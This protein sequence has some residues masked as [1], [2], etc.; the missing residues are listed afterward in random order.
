MIS[1]R[2][3]SFAA[4][5][6]TFIVLGGTLVGLSCAEERP[7][8]PSR[9]LPPLHL[10]GSY[11]VQGL[12]REVGSDQSRDIQGMLILAEADLE[13]SVSFH[14]TTMYPSQDGVLPAEVVGSGKGSVSGRSLQGSAA[15]QLILG[16]VPGEAGR[17][18]L[19]PRVYGPRL[20]SRS[21]GT[22]EDDG[23][24]V[25]ESRN[26]AAPGVSYRATRTTLRGVRV[27]AR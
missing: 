22:I 8:A 19:A 3:R 15:T 5:G 10:S 20:V 17:F 14:L 11:R 9:E 27:S 18:P 1:E 2:L 4:L 6:G 24:L 23:T 26:E 7:S 13:Y 12:T 16:M 21:T 25:F